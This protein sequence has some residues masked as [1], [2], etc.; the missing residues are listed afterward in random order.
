MI[1][2]R[3]QTNT[4]LKETEQRKDSHG[5]HS[6]RMIHSANNLSGQHY[7]KAW[8]YARQLTKVHFKAS[9]ASIIVGGEKADNSY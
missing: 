6:L 1:P 5:W 7:V 9:G 3:L 4:F 8:S 2:G